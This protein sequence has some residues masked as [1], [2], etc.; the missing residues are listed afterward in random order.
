M[1]SDVSY[2]VRFYADDIFEY[3]EE[4]YYNFE[5]DARNHAY[6]FTEEDGYTAIQI[7]RLNWITHE[8]TEIELIEF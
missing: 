2:I 4:Y 3:T 5:D 8:E 6:M 1:F 7:I